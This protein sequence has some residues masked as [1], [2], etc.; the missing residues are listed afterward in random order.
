MITRRLAIY[1]TNSTRHHRARLIIINGKQRKRPR[2][3]S[4]SDNENC[5]GNV[6]SDERKRF[7]QIIKEKDA[8]IQCLQ[9]RI[10]TFRSAMES[11]KNAFQGVLDADTDAVDDL[12]EEG[13]TVLAHGLTLNNV[14]WLVI[15]DQKK[16]SAFVSCLAKEL[17]GDQTLATSCVKESK[18]TKHLTVLSPNRVRV[19]EREYKKFLKIKNF[20][21]EV[22]MK[23]LN[24]YL[25]S[26]IGTAKQSIRTM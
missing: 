10:Q 17:Y 22:E 11:S 19:I 25:S 24:K 9:Q 21:L 1:R 12:M 15:R 13:D 20:D 26:A 18:K 7:L 6:T 23:N 4:S 14:V 2:I 16:P 8:K 3:S 5:L